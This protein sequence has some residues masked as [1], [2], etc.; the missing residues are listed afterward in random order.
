MNKPIP[1]KTSNLDIG[2]LTWTFFAFF[3][4]LFFTEFSESRKFVIPLSGILRSF[5]VLFKPNVVVH[6]KSLI[7]TVTTEF[8]L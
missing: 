3:S 6:L 1:S 5:G 7:H 8:G 2:K 4:C